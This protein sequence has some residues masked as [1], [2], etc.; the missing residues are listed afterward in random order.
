MTY[1]LTA[2]VLVVEYGV[3]FH[4]PQTSS[5]NV[6]TK[7]CLKICKKEFVNNNKILSKITVIIITVIT[8]TI[9]VIVVTVVFAATLI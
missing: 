4:T 3:D 6:A 5:R 8:V 7:Y 1:F 9:V 2:A